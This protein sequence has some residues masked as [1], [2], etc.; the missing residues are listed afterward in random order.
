LGGRSFGVV[1]A[2][3]KD[4]NVEDLIADVEAKIARLF[5]DYAEPDWPY[6]SKPRV[7]FIK[8]TTYED[9]TDRL[10]RRAEWANVEDET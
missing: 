9:A 8:K 1:E 4:T 5:A 6:R 7:Q 2:V 3:H 10:A